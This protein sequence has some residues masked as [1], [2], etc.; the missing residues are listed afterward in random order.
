MNI[1]RDFDYMQWASH[2]FLTGELPDDWVS[3]DKVKLFE[4]LEYHAWEPYE[5]TA[6]RDIYEMIGLLAREAH[7][8]FKPINAAPEPSSIKQFSGQRHF[9]G[10]P[11]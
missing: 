11:Q 8:T 7:R 6:G 1:M 4:Y 5:H 10:T 2:T 9:G 3:W